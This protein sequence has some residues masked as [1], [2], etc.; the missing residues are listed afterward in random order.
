MT[1]K[2]TPWANNELL[3]AFAKYRKRLLT[4]SCLSVRPSAWDNSALSGRIFYEIWY[5]RTFRK[6]VEKIHVLL[7]SDKSTGCFTRRPTYIY[8]NIAESFSNE[9]YFRQKSYR[10]QKHTFYTQQ[11]F[12]ENRA[13]FETMW[14]TLYSQRGQ[15]RKTTP[16]HKRCALRTG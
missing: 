13:V 12:F 9:I 6:S 11:F 15:I 16:R 2:Y 8:D 7:K 3:N 4:S 5:L 14:K 10:K 1:N